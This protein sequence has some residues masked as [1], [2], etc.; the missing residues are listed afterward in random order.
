MVL[1]LYLAACIFAHDISQHLRIN[2]LRCSQK[3]LV[4]RNSYGR[5]K[6]I[7][8]MKRSFVWSLL[9]LERSACWRFSHYWLTCVLS[10]SS[11]TSCRAKALFQ[12]LLL[13]DER[14]GYSSF[15]LCAK[16]CS[17]LKEC[18]S[19]VFALSLGCWVETMCSSCWYKGDV[20]GSVVL[21]TS[22]CAKAFFL[23]W[24]S[25]SPKTLLNRV[26]PVGYLAKG[27][28]VKL[29][30]SPLYPGERFI[31]SQKGLD[32][33]SD[34]KQPFWSWCLGRCFFG[35]VQESGGIIPV[36]RLNAAG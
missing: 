26:K 6:K 11:L 32:W 33:K 8:S 23:N 5:G 10:W 1:S 16:G 35:V 29:G 13:S 18:S 24:N 30:F 2:W 9:N 15:F 21:L 36:T 14:C 27:D 34:W 20:D 7:K 31:G 25:Q 22:N 3:R 19:D 28:H 4:F 17:C 12:G